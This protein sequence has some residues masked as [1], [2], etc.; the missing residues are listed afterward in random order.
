MAGYTYLGGVFNTSPFVPT[1]PKLS[2]ESLLVKYDS[3]GKRLWWK[4]FGSLGDDEARQ[5]TTDLEGNIYLSGLSEADIDGL[6]GRG[7]EDT[8]IMKFSPEGKKF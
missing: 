6:A 3:S 5:V 1:Y 2:R 8:Y 7:H 4:Q